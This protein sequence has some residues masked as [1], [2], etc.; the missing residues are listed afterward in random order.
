MENLNMKTEE[1]ERAAYAAGDID[2]AGL[3]ARIDELQRALG[4]AVAD[5]LT[6]LELLEA[7][8]DMLLERVDELL[9]ELAELREGM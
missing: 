7:E 9:G 8:R 5:E 6:K 3:L 4:E 1:L 2:R